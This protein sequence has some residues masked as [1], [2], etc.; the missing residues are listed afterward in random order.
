M[1]IAIVRAFNCIKSNLLLT[2]QEKTK[3]G[4]AWPNEVDV[5]ELG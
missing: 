1:T 3:K 5:D 4:K 2:E